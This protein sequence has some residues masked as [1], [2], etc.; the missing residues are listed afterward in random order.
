MN[1]F[2]VESLRSHF[3]ALQRVV[4]GGHP[5]FLDGPGGTQVPRSV[6][7]AI[8]HYLS[9]CNANHGGVF[10]TSQESD[11]IVHDAHAAVARL[12]NAP[13]PDEIVFGQ[14]MTSLTFH[15][16]RSLAL[17]W[18]PGDEVLVT[19][20]DHDANVR[21]WVLAAQDAGATVRFIDIHPED[22]TLDLADL[23]A[24]LTVRTKLLAVGAASNV[25]GT[26]NDIA[27]LT[28]MAHAV[29][30]KVYVDAVHYSP[31]GPIDV[32]AWDCDFLA[33]SAYKFFGPH[34]GILWGRRRWLE[35]LVPYKVRPCAD[36][37]PDRWMTG[38]QNHEGLAGVVAAV[39]YLEEIG[40]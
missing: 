34:V 35:E 22:C 30:A 1:A 8:A 24:K 37:I 32:Q 20:L 36:T 19:R 13:S 16:S 40:D 28:K 31:H 14:N 38:T 17:T 21:P 12:L 11:Q 25:V 3:P 5:V 29:G 10:Q 23:R 4:E 18:K 2:P 7:V 15:V 27:A 33:C 9:T 39:A 6:I 26:V